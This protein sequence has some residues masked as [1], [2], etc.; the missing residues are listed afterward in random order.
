MPTPSE[1]VMST[2]SPC[3]LRGESRSSPALQLADPVER[4]ARKAAPAS[5]TRNGS[6]GTR[7]KSNPAAGE[8]PKAG[9]A[10]KEQHRHELDRIVASVA[11]VGQLLSELGP[12]DVERAL[13]VIFAARC[14]LDKT[15]RQLVRL[16]LRAGRSWARIG[17]ALGICTGRATHE[18]FGDTR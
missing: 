14:Q 8:S 3:A 5:P 15:E 9:L 4:T 13:E 7:F 10:L 11:E 17:A 12:D 16:A 18:R 1:A 6:Y 2:F